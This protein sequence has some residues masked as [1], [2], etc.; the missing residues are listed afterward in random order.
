MNF[1][2]SR[3]GSGSVR[4]HGGATLTGQHASTHYKPEALHRLLDLAPLP[5]PQPERLERWTDKLAGTAVLD[6]LAEL[7]DRIGLEWQRIARL[8]AVS[9]PALNK[10][11]TG[12]GLAPDSDL[13]LRRLV[14]F[15]ELLAEAGVQDIAAWFLARPVPEAPFTRADLYQLGAAGDL[16]DGVYRGSDAREL[17]DRWLPRWREAIP[18]SA[19]FQP[20]VTFDDDGSATILVPELPGVLAV[21]A[22]LDE[23][24]QQLLQEVREYAADWEHMSDA[25]NHA[26]NKER[27]EAILNAASDDDLYGLVFGRRSPQSGRATMNS[28]VETTAGIGPAVLATTSGRSDCLMDGSSGRPFNGTRPNMGRV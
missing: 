5:S 18:T 19:L 1:S 20:S 7:H 25:P 11:R 22:T 13:G 14:A 2:D 17:L 27:V 28:S 24:R 23:A 3:T 26:G 10:W 16:L 4:I 15:C 12:G 21:G 9:V 8:L 6:L